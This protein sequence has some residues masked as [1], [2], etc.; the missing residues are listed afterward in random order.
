MSPRKTLLLAFGLILIVIVSG[1]FTE[2]A[3][4]VVAGGDEG[5]AV[6]VT[7]ET[8]P[9]FSLKNVAG[10]SVRLSDYRNKKAVVVAFWA[11][12]CLPCQYELPSIQS[13]YQ[14]NRG[15]DVEVLAVSIDHDPAAAR[16]YAESNKLPFPVLLDSREEVATRYLVNE[17]PAVFVIDRGGTLES[18]HRG[19]SPGLEATLTAEVRGNAGAPP[20]QTGQ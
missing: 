12:W 19:L 14:K 2:R 17:I 7:G 11:S 15:S 20:G 10:Q 13:F 5:G 4:Q 3:R 6:A 9:D 16:G 1:W 18:V 8:A